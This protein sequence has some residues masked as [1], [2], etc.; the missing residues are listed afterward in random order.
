MDYFGQIWIFTEGMEERK[1]Y[2]YDCEELYER[3]KTD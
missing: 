1:V 3:L 2:A